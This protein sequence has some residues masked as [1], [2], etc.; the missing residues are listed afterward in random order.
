[1]D[2]Q[3][4]S[5]RY[6]VSRDYI[7]KN[8]KRFKDEAEMKTGKMEVVSG[9]VRVTVADSERYQRNRKAWLDEVSLKVIKA[10]SAKGVTRAEMKELILDE[11]SETDTRRVVQSHALE[12]K[13]PKSRTDRAKSQTVHNYLVKFGPYVD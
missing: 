12:A 6:N 7:W 11:V 13:E 5:K 9:P 2:V 8:A 10:R 1:M 3:S 4:I